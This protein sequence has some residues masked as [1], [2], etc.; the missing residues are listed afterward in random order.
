MEKGAEDMVV[1]AATAV[2]VIGTKAAAVTSS[3]RQNK[4]LIPASILYCANV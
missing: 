4:V 3:S 2:G 1:N